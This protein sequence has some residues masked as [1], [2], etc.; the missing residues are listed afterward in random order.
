VALVNDGP[1]CTC[2]IKLSVS[3]VMTDR[4]QVTLEMSVGPSGEKASSN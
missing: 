3:N 2:T 1:V 4:I